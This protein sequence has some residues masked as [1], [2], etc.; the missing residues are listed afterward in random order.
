MNN[1]PAVIIGGAQGADSLAA[2]YALEKNIKLTV[3]KPDWSKYGRSAGIVRNKEIISNCDY[4]IAFWDGISKGTESSI[5][6]CKKLN[7][8]YKIVNY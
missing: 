3:Y 8:P 6:L 1:V 4:C 5:N 7:K 2:Q